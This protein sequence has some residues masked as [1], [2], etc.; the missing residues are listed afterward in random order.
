MKKQLERKLERW[1]THRSRVQYSSWTKRG[2]EG[3]IRQTDIENGKI[4]RD[5]S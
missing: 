5:K 4:N 1:M 2:K 3:V